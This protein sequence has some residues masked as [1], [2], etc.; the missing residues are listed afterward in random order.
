MVHDAMVSCQ[1]RFFLL[2]ETQTCGVAS[3]GTK[4]L[5]FGDKGL[6]SRRSQAVY[7]IN[8]M[9]GFLGQV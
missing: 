9:A 2:G 8:D 1:K 4:P 7:T 3:F 5:V 6:F